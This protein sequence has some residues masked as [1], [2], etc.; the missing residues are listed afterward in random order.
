[1][2]WEPPVKVFS[3]MFRY[4]ML[5]YNWFRNF[6]VK[7]SLLTEPQES[8]LKI[9]HYTVLYCIE[10]RPWYDVEYTCNHIMSCYIAFFYLRSPFEGSMGSSS[11]SAGCRRWT[12]LGQR[13]WGTA[14]HWGYWSGP[15]GCQVPPQETPGELECWWWKIITRRRDT[16]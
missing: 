8:P 14:Q 1:M 5:T 11:V 16:A 15:S 2:V 6:S 3:T 13:R 9:S 4:V 10:L 7:C 12:S